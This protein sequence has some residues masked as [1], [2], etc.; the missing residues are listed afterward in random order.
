MQHDKSLAGL[1][2]VLA[3][4]NK[5]KIT[6]DGNDSYCDGPNKHINI[7]RMDN[8]P[9][10]R[11]LME[12][13]IFHEADGHMNYTDKPKP[14]GML[15][16]MTNVIEDVRVEALV[17]ANRPGA[18]FNLGAVT[19]HYIEKG[20]L[21]PENL[22]HAL[23]G[24]VMAYGRGRLL[25]Q[26]S[27]APLEKECDEMLDDAFGETFIDEL[28]KIIAGIPKLKDTTGTIAMARKVVDLILN[29]PPPPTPPPSQ[30]QQP[31]KSD[32]DDF[33]DQQDAPGSQQDAPGGDQRDGEGD[34]EGQQQDA[35]P[36]T[37]SGDDQPTQG[38]GKASPTKEEIQEM[39]QKESGFGDLSK[40]LHQEMNDLAGK[41]SDDCPLLPDI[42]TWR[43][44]NAL[45]E[46]AAIATS[47]RMRQKMIGLLESVKR[48]PTTF[49]LNG[50]KIVPGRLTKLAL[51]DPRVFQK[52]TE[53]FAANTAVVI[54]SDYSGSMETSDINNVKRKDVSIPATY[55]L[56]HTLYGLRDVACC[57]LGFVGDCGPDVHLLVDFGVK[58]KSGNFN[59]PCPGSTPMAQAL[60]AARAKLMNR[61]EPRK[62]ILVMTDGDPD[63]YDETHAAVKSINEAGIDLAA[64]GIMDDAVKNFFHNHRV[65]YQLSDL[66]SEL[67]SVMDT[68]LTKRRT[69]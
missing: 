38:S 39:L 40:L 53:V 1:A 16:D 59:H 47:S 62:I 9:L 26:A 13:L 49:G 24:K 37:S 43:Q 64:I 7:A 58:P 20:S 4:S 41:A 36:E 55:A 50:K 54:L 22:N 33:G 14:G 15:G 61:P 31:S 6:V 27:I 46:V 25:Q 67:F 34:S 48:K 56:H 69:L 42:G 52:K 57:S 19:K 10:G 11:M 12:G 23:L 2:M 51:G 68:M 65:I 66:P 44:E 8:T 35:P 18:R 28:E 63:D 5:I 29:P 21:K 60:W 30:Q 3:K 32:D 45:D 17:I